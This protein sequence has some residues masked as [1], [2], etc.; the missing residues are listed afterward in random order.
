MEHPALTVREVFLTADA[1]ARRAALQQL[2]DTWLRAL[3][4][5]AQP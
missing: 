4:R 3:A 5:Q 1:A 2:A